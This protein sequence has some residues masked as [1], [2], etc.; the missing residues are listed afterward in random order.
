V[1][2]NFFSA[3]LLLLISELF[4]P[5]PVVRVHRL[6]LITIGTMVF[7]DDNNLIHKSGTKNIC[8]QIMALTFVKKAVIVTI[9]RDIIN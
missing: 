3:F 9:Q 1:V 4:I 6:L 7:V 5:P 2:P 8:C